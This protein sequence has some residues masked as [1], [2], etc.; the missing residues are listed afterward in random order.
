MYMGLFLF[1]TSVG[2]GAES[3]RS[4]TRKSPLC[5]L[6]LEIAVPTILPLE[7]PGSRDGL[8]VISCVY[9]RKSFRYS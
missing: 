1:V 5:V 7:Y 8:F 6:E 4:V 2:W 9:V 3:H